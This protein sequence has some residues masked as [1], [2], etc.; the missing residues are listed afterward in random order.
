MKH[1]YKVEVIEKVDTQ[2]ILLFVTQP[3]VCNYAA[4][5]AV[6]HHAADIAAAS[7]ANLPQVS[8]VSLMP[9]SGHRDGFTIIWSY[10]DGQ[11]IVREVDLVRI[12]DAR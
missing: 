9:F 6:L 1:L 5:R 11:Q 8:G 10:P 7:V 3:F 12:G 2:P 4:A